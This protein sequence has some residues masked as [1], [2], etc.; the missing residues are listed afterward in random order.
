M[1]ER[2]SDININIQADLSN[3]CAPS[4]EQI[5]PSKG[6]HSQENLQKRP[7]S[8]FILLSLHCFPFSWHSASS[9]F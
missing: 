2:H 6:G 3:L 1:L 8:K 7:S 4:K 9:N 5:Q